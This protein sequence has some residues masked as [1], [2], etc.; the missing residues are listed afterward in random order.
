MKS[1]MKES[2]FA[3][4]IVHSADGLKTLANTKL[5]RNKA[6]CVAGEF[7]IFI[8]MLNF[9]KITINKNKFLSKGSLCK[10]CFF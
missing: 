2:P 1:E 6:N 7:E 10:V 8:I 9:A 5:Q 4:T 3:S